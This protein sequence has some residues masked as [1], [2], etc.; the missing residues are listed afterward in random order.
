MSTDWGSEFKADRLCASLHSR[1]ESK[2]EEEEGSGF[3]VYMESEE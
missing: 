3:G 2:D 1:L